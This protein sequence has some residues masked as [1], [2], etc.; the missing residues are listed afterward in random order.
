MADYGKVSE[1][2]EATTVADSDL[3]EISQDQ[4]GSY[5]SKK[6]TGANS[7]NKALARDQTAPQLTVGTFTFPDMRTVNSGS[8]TRDVATGLV[9]GVVLTGLRS[10]SIARNAAGYVTGVSDGTKTWTYVRDSNNAIVS[11]SVA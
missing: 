3:I 11:W 5:V 7:V 6:V 8:V 10:L 9:S 1:L 4:G 2:V